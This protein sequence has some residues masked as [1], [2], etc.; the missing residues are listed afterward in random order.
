MSVSYGGDSI[1]FGDG[2]IVA[3][4]SAGFKNKV[5]N[6]AMMIDQRYAGSANTPVGS[7]GGT[8][9]IDRWC[10]QCS[11]A[12]KMSIQQVQTANTSASNYEASSAPSNYINAMKFTVASANTVSSGDYYNLY[13]AI[14][15]YNVAD[16]GW[17][18]ASAQTVTL[19]FWVKSSITGTYT[20]CLKNGDV[21][22]SYPYTYTINS[23]NTWEYKTI[24]VSG[25]T[26]GTWK[27]DN[28]VGLYVGFNLGVGS[29]YSGGTVNI[30]NA[31]NTQGISGQT[32]L[33]GASNS[34]ATWYI[35]GV[36]LEKSTTASTFE[37]RSIQKEL[38][39]CQR[40]FCKTFPQSVAPAQ[41]ADYLGTCLVWNS[42]G[43]NNAFGTQVQW[44][45]PVTMRATPTATYY[46]PKAANASAR[47]AAIGGDMALSST[48]IS[49][50]GELAIQFVSG[51]TAS[52]PGHCCVIH[53]TASAEL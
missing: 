17:G 4:G 45:L 32:S 19:S 28:T 11:P 27:K 50:L 15:G 40:Y 13:Q 16:L 51:D 3:S 5:I 1:T 7:G 41:N 43:S 34:G 25:D 2:S 35:T 42:S 49:G 14:E 33:Q 23:A 18:T 26:G 9:V 39:L 46:N 8:Y 24:T 44:R 22:R 21:N 48:P 52:G 20:G 53:A 10:F 12:S 31:I 38:I 6:G 30:W 36:Q 29:S 47:N 37:F